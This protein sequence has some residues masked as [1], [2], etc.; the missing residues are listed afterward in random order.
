GVLNSCVRLLIK[1]YCNWY[2]LLF[3][4]M[5]RKTMYNVPKSKKYMTSSPLMTG[6]KRL[7]T[8]F[9]MKVSEA[10][11][12]SLYSESAPGNGSSVIRKGRWSVTP[13]DTTGRMWMFSYN[14]GNLFT[15]FNL[16][17]SISKTNKSW[18]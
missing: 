17:G 14:S 16:V 5:L 9:V 7:F 1:S 3:T 12:C 13:W 15:T 4:V 2:N 11:N 10:S 18:S 8:V 6:K